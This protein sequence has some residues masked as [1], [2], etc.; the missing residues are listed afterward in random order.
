VRVQLVT[1]EFNWA[2][3]NQLAME[4]EVGRR[5]RR[6]RKVNVNK[7]EDEGYSSVRREPRAHRA[8]WEKGSEELVGEAGEE[9]SMDELKQRLMLLREA[10][11]EIRD[12]MTRVEFEADLLKDDKIE[13][14]EEMRLQKVELRKLV[15]VCSVLQQARSADKQRI[16]SLQQQV[17]SLMADRER[18]KDD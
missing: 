6:A 2:M 14:E 4:Q 13:R 9:E 10:Y 12:Q 11:D 18:D 1:S 17:T 7:D 3:G 15:E 8:R 16:S 5:A